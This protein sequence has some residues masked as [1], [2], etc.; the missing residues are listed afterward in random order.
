MHTTSKCFVKYSIV[1]IRSLPTQNCINNENLKPE[2]L[3]DTNR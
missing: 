2:D 1:H 3:E